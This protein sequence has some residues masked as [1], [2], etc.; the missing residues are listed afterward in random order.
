MDPDLL[1]RYFPFLFGFA[2]LWV[3]GLNLASIAYR[4]AQGRPII[5]RTPPGAAF[6][7][8]AVFGH[9]NRTWYTKLRGARRCLVVAVD[10]GRLIIHPQFPFN[11][12]F[13]G[14]MY[15]VE[16]DVGVDVVTQVEW[17]RT[18]KTNRIDLR[19][20]GSGGSSEH[21][22]LYLREPGAFVRALASNGWR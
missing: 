19:F 18:G 8:T 17:D 16:H 14:E 11:L 2:L 1:D 10:S 7:E 13:M 12:M 21:L 4:R 20:R 5:L 3:V 22:T 6:V 9:S 15:G